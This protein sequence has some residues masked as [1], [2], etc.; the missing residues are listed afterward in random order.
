VID[1]PVR[2]KDLLQ[3]DALLLDRREDAVEIATGI[4]NG[5]RCVVSSISSEQ[6]C[7][8]GVTG[9]RRTFICACCGIF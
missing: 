2:Q 3:R 9:I 7:W 6:F 4:A 8:K 1:V 5:A